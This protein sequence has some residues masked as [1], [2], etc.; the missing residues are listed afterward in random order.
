MKGLEDDVILLLAELVKIPSVCGEEH[1]LAS[2]IADWLRRND[3]P[4]ELVF[5]K[6]H[7]P[8]V[9]VKLKGSEPGPRIMLNGHM[10]TVE[11]GRG[12]IHNPFGAEIEEGRMYGRGTI[13]MKSG[14]A[15]IL[16][17]AAACKREGFPKRGELTIAAV[18]DEEAIDLGTYSL[19]QNGFVKELDFAMISEATDL[20]LVTAHRGRV[21]FDI[22]VR[23][24]AVHS[25]WP[26]RGINAIDKAA[27]LLKALEKLPSHN[28]P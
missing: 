3:L 19:I 26:E 16:Q 18:V 5:V 13:D 28:T 12:W 4:A 11:A 2:F 25:H 23:G 24:R 1:Q 14:L 22:E 20:Q 21:V 6:P 10:D 27:L 8:N 15:C 9:I 7:R 17:A